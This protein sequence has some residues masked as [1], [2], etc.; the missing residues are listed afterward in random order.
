MFITNVI[1]TTKASTSLIKQGV[2]GKS[3][4]LHKKYNPTIIK[5]YKITTSI[6]RFLLIN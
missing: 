3:T 6:N 5:K 1:N 4:K 2:F